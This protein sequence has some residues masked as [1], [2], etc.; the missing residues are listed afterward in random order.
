MRERDLE[1]QVGTY[2]K[3][4]G[5]RFEKFTSP[6]NRGVPDRIVILPQGVLVFLEFKAPGKKPTILQQ[7]FIDEYRR[8][9]QH[10]YAVDDFAKARRILETHMSLV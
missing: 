4:L 5:G 2:V 6:G 3:N 1:R 10:A 8:L 7:H 9:G